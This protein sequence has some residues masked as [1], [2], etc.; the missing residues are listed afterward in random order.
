MRGA[1]VRGLWAGTGL[2]LAC[3][4]SAFVGLAAGPSAGAA[5]VARADRPVGNRLEVPL[6]AGL[7]SA[8][9]AGLVRSGAYGQNPVRLMIVGDSIA[10]TLGQGLSVGSAATYGVTV[11]DE[12]TLGCDLDPQLEVLTAGAPGP[13]TQWC[14]LWRAR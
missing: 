3:V 14:Q 7:T 6:P 11:S 8:E 2:V 9:H 12:A 13:A 4:A 5:S 1:G 10:M